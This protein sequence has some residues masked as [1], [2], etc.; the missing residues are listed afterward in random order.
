MKG[1]DRKIFSINNDA[2]YHYGHS[3]L[4]EVSVTSG[5]KC[6]VVLEAAD[7]IDSMTTGTFS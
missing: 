4:G 5:L 3:Q 7:E 2:I 6:L 1:A